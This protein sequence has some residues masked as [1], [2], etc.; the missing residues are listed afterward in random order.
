MNHLT[1]G[2]SLLLDESFA[3]KPNPTGAVWTQ[4]GVRENEANTDDSSILIHLL[5]SSENE[6][7]SVRIDRVT[8][9]AE[10]KTNIRR[11]PI[12]GSH[13]VA[14]EFDYPLS[15]AQNFKLLEF[16]KDFVESFF[17]PQLSKCKNQTIIVPYSCPLRPR[18]VATV[19]PTIW[20]EQI[21]F[22]ISS[23]HNV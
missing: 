17:S 9:A 1:T 10:Q 18:Y 5:L 8:F 20:S 7:A 19:S 13:Q 12:M 14:E 11:S 23:T 16:A 21:F 4:T 22:I 2:E 15:E 3:Y 6:L